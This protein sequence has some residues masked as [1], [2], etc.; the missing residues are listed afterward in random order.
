MDILRTMAACFSSYTHVQQG[1]VPFAESVWG[2]L[3]YEVRNG[4]VDETIQGTLEVIRSLASRLDGGDLAPFAFLVTRDCFDDLSDT[5]YLEQSGKLLLAVIG[6][7]PRSFAVVAP[8][9]ITQC[10]ATLRH[11]KDTEHSAGLLSLVNSI[12]QLRI[13]ILAKGISEIGI[14]AQAIR[15]TDPTILAL[16]DEV[17]KPNF[18]FLQPLNVE[19]PSN[20][21]RSDSTNSIEKIKQA[22]TG[23]GLL[24]SQPTVG[25]SPAE[26]RSLLPVS[27]RSEICKILTEAIRHPLSMVTEVGQFESMVMS[28]EVVP[29]AVSAMQRVAVAYPDGCKRFISGGLEYAGGLARSNLTRADDSKSH[30]HPDDEAFG[31]SRWDMDDEDDLS[32]TLRQMAYVSSAEL[33]VVGDKLDLYIHFLNS[34]LLALKDL[35]AESTVTTLAWY[36]YVAAIHFAYCNISKAL[37]GVNLDKAGWNNEVWGPDA[38]VSYIARK[39][40]QIPQLDMTESVDTSEQISRG[41]ASKGV[42]TTSSVEAQLK[43]DILLVSLFVARQLWRLGTKVTTLDGTKGGEPVLARSQLVEQVFARPDGLVYPGWDEYWSHTAKLTASICRDL[44]AGQQDQLKLAMEC[45]CGFRARDSLPGSGGDAAAEPS[46][47]DRVTANCV[48]KT[49]NLSRHRKHLRFPFVDQQ[50]FIHPLRKH[51]DDILPAFYPAS[52]KDLVRMVLRDGGLS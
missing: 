40:P 21:E 5:K 35:M 31:S 10:K 7:S 30:P 17:Y 23:C 12:L 52:L 20:V 49:A 41:V 48:Q 4:E 26:F 47:A 33:P 44:T 1:I 3:K 2:S 51:L 19:P 28:N 13:E 39:F 18:R 15:G 36:P 16:F 9:T 29:C 32:V 34:V 37:E 46:F 38:W 45:I 11:P 24:I 27:T 50:R 8:A 42:S 25:S 6:A 14:D 43:Q 22:I